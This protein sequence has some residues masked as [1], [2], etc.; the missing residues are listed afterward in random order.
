[1]R[2]L[3]DCWEVLMST[4]ADL[5]LFSLNKGGRGGGD[6]KPKTYPRKAKTLKRPN[7]VAVCW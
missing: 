6:G 4:E 7:A 5:W 2:W 3:N 1:M